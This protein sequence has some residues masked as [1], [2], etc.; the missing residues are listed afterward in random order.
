MAIGGGGFAARPPDPALDE[1][2]LAVAGMTAPRI[3]LPPTAGRR[4]DQI[5]RFYRA[6]HGL[7]CEPSHS[8][9]FRLGA[10]SI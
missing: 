5:E 4:S 6:Y 10:L 2:M 1:Y 9:L 3:C 8:S 7:D